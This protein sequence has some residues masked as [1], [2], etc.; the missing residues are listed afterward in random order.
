MRMNVSVL[1]M[2]HVTLSRGHAAVNLDGV[3]TCVLRFARQTHM[4]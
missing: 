4:D 2:A 3:E 1:T